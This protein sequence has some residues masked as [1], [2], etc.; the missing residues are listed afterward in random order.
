[1]AVADASNATTTRQQG[2]V[3]QSN[4]G[5]DSIPGRNSTKVTVAK[6][7]SAASASA[8]AAS[9]KAASSKA[10]KMPTIPASVMDAILA[11][12]LTATEQ[13]PQLLDLSLTL[14]PLLWSAGPQLQEAHSLETAAAAFADGD[15]ALAALRSLMAHANQLCNQM[16][17]G[18]PAELLA[19]MA[20]PSPAASASPAPFPSLAAAALLA[21]M[22]VQ[23]STYTLPSPASLHQLVSE[24]FASGLTPAPGAPVSRGA[25]TNVRAVAI[26]AAH[27]TSLGS[28]PSHRQLNKLLGLLSPHAATLPEAELLSLMGMCLA[29]DF[30]LPKPLAVRC[31]ARCLAAWPDL[32]GPA[33]L[34]TIVNAAAHSGCNAGDVGASAEQ[35]TGLLAE[36]RPELASLASS[37]LLPLLPSLALLQPQSARASAPF[38]AWTS[39][40]CAAVLP[41]LAA[42]SDVQLQRVLG[43]LATFNHTPPALM[44]YLACGYAEDH[45]T[46]TTDS[47]TSI[48]AASAVALLRHLVLQLNVSPL[49]A[50]GEGLAGAWATYTDAAAAASAASKA[51]A[52]L[53][54][55]AFGELPV[56]EMVDV[57]HIS[58]RLGVRMHPLQLT[59]LVKDILE[60]STKGKKQVLSGA[61]TARMLWACVQF[62]FV[63]AKR[64]LSYL[65]ERLVES[66][67]Q[68]DPATGRNTGVVPAGAMTMAQLALAMRS[69][70]QLGCIPSAEKQVGHGLFGDCLVF[71]NTAWD[72]KR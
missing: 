16:P 3:K 37:Q 32:G 8:A 69:L 6:S 58:A 7:N 28:T 59:G 40:Y 9:A 35:L 44:M 68:H 63:P 19:E 39:S 42:A 18:L 23:P 27:C 61:D 65:L 50:T 41:H 33:S 21:S 57:L 72:N 51:A 20:P 48:S 66:A 43:A 56:G 45:L 70:M 38:A 25:P 54:S 1:M 14:T 2:S 55:S 5:R 24:L 62:R 29:A 17:Y 46:A 15:S 11:D 52:G 71:C 34:A 26:A 30:K 4:S 22:R 47:R 36:L 49:S 12:A 60:A 31:V 10:S 64:L 67:H 13:Q 53:T